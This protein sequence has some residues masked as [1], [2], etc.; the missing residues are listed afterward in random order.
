MIA[1]DI[2]T[3]EDK[4]LYVQDTKLLEVLGSVDEA[5]G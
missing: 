1:R 4:H 3:F 5:P 2:F